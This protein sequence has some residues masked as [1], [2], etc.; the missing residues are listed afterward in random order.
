MFRHFIRLANYRAGN[1][2]AAASDSL[3]YQA[4]FKGA[5]IFQAETGGCKRII[6]YVYQIPDDGIKCRSR[7]NTSQ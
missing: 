1:E 3:T 7:R 2:L 6:F 5:Y 4:E